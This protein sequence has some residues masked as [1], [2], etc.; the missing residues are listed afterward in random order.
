MLEGTR[1]APPDEYT[2]DLARATEGGAALAAEL[3]ASLD[4]GAQELARLR[5]GT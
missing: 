3:R 2:A 5:Q 4:A 1:A